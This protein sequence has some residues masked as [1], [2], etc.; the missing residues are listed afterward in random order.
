MKKHFILFWSLEQS[1]SIQIMKSSY[2]SIIYVCFIFN[3]GWR[4]HDWS[5][6]Y[7]W[8]DFFFQR[9]TVSMTSGFF[10]NLQT[11]SI[12]RVFIEK[13]ELFNQHWLIERCID[14]RTK[15]CFCVQRKS[16]LPFLS[17]S[18]SLWSPWCMWWAA[19]WCGPSPGT[20]GWLPRAGWAWCGW[21]LRN[22]TAAA[23]ACIDCWTWLWT[24]P[25]TAGWCHPGRWN[26][27]TG[28]ALW[29]SLDVGLRRELV[30]ATTAEL[31]LTA[32]A[33]AEPPGGGGKERPPPGSN[34]MLGISFVLARSS[35]SVPTTKRGPDDDDTVMMTVFWKIWALN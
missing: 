19:G 13:I 5:T 8:Y 18:S 23:W 29:K 2:L 32:V 28:V 15:S 21:W 14:E 3:Q 17:S 26:G 11:A 16:T 35:L 27:N 25:S 4:L 10:T 31:V 30:A 12:N 24:W 34:T 22:L 9:E 7:V 1:K 6:S 20:R 33:A